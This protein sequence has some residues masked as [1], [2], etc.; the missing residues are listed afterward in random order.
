MQN[1]P[2]KKFREDLGWLAMRWSGL[3]LMVELSCAYLFQA[4]LVETKDPKPPKPFGARVKFIR[5]QLTHPAFT[6]LRGE[7]EVALR[8]A[9][10]LSVERN[11]RM[12][13]AYT[14]WSDTNPPQQTLIKSHETGY[15]AIQDISVTAADISD[16]SERIGDAFALHFNLMDRIKALIRAYKGNAELGRRMRFGD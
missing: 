9:E 1:R 12:H 10:S 4:G 13:G 14:S 7:Y 15:V 8:L 5:R 6:H 2:P 3:E 16:L 11:H